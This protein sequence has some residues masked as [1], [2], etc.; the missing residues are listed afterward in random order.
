MKM[1]A[2]VSIDKH[3]EGFVGKPIVV[4]FQDQHTL[5]Q[6]YDVQQHKFVEEFAVDMDLLVDNILHALAFENNMKDWVFDDTFVHDNIVEDELVIVVDAMEML[7]L[8]QV[9]QHQKTEILLVVKVHMLHAFVFEN[10][11]KDQVF[12]DTFVHG[13]IV[14]DKLMTAHDELVI[15]E[16][17]LV[18][19]EDE[20]EM[21]P[22]EQVV[23]H[24][25][26]VTLLEVKVDVML[27]DVEGLE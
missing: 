16:G 1:V 13:S 4:V 18:I 11:M 6:G 24:Q 8:E 26:K 17:E 23:Q 19:V 9:V 7:Q 2:G 25:K 10:N 27:E 5:F 12:D 3:F 20:N 22:L 15:V 21:L 14:E